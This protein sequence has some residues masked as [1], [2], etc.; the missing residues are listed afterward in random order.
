MCIRSVRIPQL[1]DKVTSRH[2]QKGLFGQIVNREDLPFDPQT[3]MSP[4]II[5][6]SHAKVSRMTNGHTFE[7]L[8][9]LVCAN[10]GIEGDATAFERGRDIEILK[11]KLFE[12]G[13]RPEDKK[14]I[15]NPLL[16]HTKG[17]HK[18]QRDGQVVLYCG[19]TGKRLKEVGFMGPCYY[20]KLK[21]F[22]CDKIHARDRGPLTLVCRQPVE[23]R[24]R[25]GGLRFGEMERDCFVGY[26]IALQLNASL[27]HNSDASEGIVCEQCGD[28]GFSNS[29]TKLVRGSKI[30][31]DK[32]LAECK[33]CGNTYRFQKVAI[34][35]SLK[36]LFTE[37]KAMHINPKIM[38]QDISGNS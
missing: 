23:G 22:V 19:K 24:A 34:P 32:P 17:R 18:H 37:L 33:R 27:M 31:T 15:G 10:Y 12:Y 11:D 30:N 35:H 6:N 8:Y 4:D 28:L 36:V 13:R 14:D 7:T 9:G 2:G 25:D 16:S 29:R 5:L 21:H 26:G 3:G 38:L 1:G 20:Q